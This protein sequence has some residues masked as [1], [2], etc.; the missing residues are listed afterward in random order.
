ML[1]LYSHSSLHLLHLMRNRHQ[2]GHC[3]EVV[4][5]WVL[6]S[7]GLRKVVS[8]PSRGSMEDLATTGHSIALVHEE[9]LHCWRLDRASF[10]TTLK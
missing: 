6:G 2:G 5:P 7:A 9:L 3:I 10:G 8:V 1:R 4:F